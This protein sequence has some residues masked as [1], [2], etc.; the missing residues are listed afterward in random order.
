M[1]A[2]WEYKVVVH[3][4]G[5]KGF[6]YEQIE[7]DLTELGRDGWEAVS[8][9]SPSVGQGQAMDLATLLKRPAG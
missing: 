7:K 8:T 6:K 3:K 5:W 2:Q 1:A 9:V 4:F